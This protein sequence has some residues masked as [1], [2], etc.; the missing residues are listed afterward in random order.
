MGI[1]KQAF[2]EGAALHQLARSTELTSLKYEAPFFVLNRRVL[3]YLKYSTKTRSPWGFTFTEEEQVLLRRRATSDRITI[4]LICGGDGVAT[5]SYD[6]FVGIAAPKRTAIHVA[7]YRKH[8]EQY[9]VSG[10]DGAI[11][12]KIAPSDWMRLLG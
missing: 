12:R 6:D 1:A 3:V 7:C 8:K 11:A 10:P 5:V 9:E 2:Y 4:G